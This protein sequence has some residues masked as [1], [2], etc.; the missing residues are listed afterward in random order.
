[1]KSLLVAAL[2]LL[3]ISS[4]HAT[5][6]Q[7]W[8]AIE[9]PKT[10]LLCTNLPFVNGSD[11]T[12]QN[13][14]MVIVEGLGMKKFDIRVQRYVESSVIYRE[15]AERQ[16]E[17]PWAHDEDDPMSW[18]KVE[19]MTTNYYSTGDFKNLEYGEHF[20]MADFNG[21]KGFQF[22]LYTGSGNVSVVDKVLVFDAFVFFVNKNGKAEGAELKCGNPHA[23]EREKKYGD[24]FGNGVYYQK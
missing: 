24:V 13:A 17:M 8:E 20:Q 15:V 1:M 2:A 3:S 5:H 16:M 10:A 6:E 4:L 18:L 21:K 7:A 23:Y 22:T 12:Q 11:I 19:D 14:I 9:N